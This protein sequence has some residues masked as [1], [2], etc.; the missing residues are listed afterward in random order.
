MAK[1]LWKGIY[2]TQQKYI[3]PLT[4]KNNLRSSPWKYT[5]TNVKQDIHKFTHCK[6]LTD[7]KSIVRKVAEEQDI[8]C[9]NVSSHNI[10]SSNRKLYI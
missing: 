2:N 8:L 7:A 5:P 4:Y 3:F 9:I 1:D 6:L 10:F